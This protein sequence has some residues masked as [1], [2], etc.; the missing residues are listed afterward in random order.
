MLLDLGMQ[1][2]KLIMIKKIVL[3]LLLLNP[4]FGFSQN[5]IND[6]SIEVERVIE[7][8]QNKDKVHYDSLLAI[9]KLGNANNK[10]E[11]IMEILNACPLEDNHK[12][13]PEAY[14]IL[15]EALDTAKTKIGIRNLTIN[16]ANIHVFEAAHSMH[17]EN[18]ESTLCCRTRSRK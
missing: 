4:F 11:L 1:K 17:L 15:N 12:Y 14:K 5:K 9:H 16:Q 13:I 3:S 18:N 10:L 7:T 8:I 2:R 6:K